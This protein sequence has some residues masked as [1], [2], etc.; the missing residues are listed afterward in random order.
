MCWHPERDAIGRALL[1]KEGLRKIAERFAVS[2]TALHR[3][4]TRGIPRGLV[5]AVEA[6]AL[7]HQGDLLEQVRGLIA[8]AQS[9]LGQAEGR[10]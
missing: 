3:H 7:A 6:Q 2:T 1:G 9:I 5:R 10:G 4:K 8:S